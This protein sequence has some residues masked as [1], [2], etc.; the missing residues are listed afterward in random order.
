MTKNKYKNIKFD[1]ETI[2][3]TKPTSS[4]YKPLVVSEISPRAGIIG[5]VGRKLNIKRWGWVEQ[6]ITKDVQFIT[7]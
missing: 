1:K 6:E 5:W 2:T 7:R 4:H 3:G